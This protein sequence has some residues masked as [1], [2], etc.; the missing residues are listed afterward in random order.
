[1][2]NIVKVK[3]LDELLSMVSQIIGNEEVE[4]I[5]EECKMS[6][7][8]LHAEICSEIHSTFIEKNERY[9]NS[10]SEQFSEFGMQS[11]IIRLSDKLNRL[12]TLTKNSDMDT[13]DESIY[14]TL[15]DLSNYCIMT[16][17]ELE[18]EGE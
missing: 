1:M 2:I 11:V 15:K 6:D 7:R 14:D 3:S 16:M 17:V 5:K 12:K 9:G 18:K 10:F 13:L 8:E 4:Q